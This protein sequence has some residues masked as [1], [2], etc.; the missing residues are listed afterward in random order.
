MEILD[1]KLIQ[2]GKFDEAIKICD[3]Q[4][5]NF[6]NNPERANVYE[7]AKKA[8]QAAQ[9]K[10]KEAVEATKSIE[11]TTVDP[12]DSTKKQSFYDKFIKDKE[13]FVTLCWLSA[14]IA[15]EKSSSSIEAGS[16]AAADELKLN[17]NEIETKYDI[18]DR[19]K[20]IT[21]QILEG[22]GVAKWLTRGCLAVG[23]G[24]ILAKGVTGYLAKE[25][26]MSG[27]LGLF[28][29]GKLGISKLPALWSAI[30][31][32]VT[33]LTGWSALFVGAAAG[34]AVLKT[35]PVVSNFVK[36]IKTKYKNAHTY[37]QGIESLL[38]S[39]EATNLTI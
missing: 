39:Q 8:L 16:V 30:G 3:K 37:E 6:K 17:A 36:S 28:G 35:I 1:P 12:T 2:K 27:A 10:L 13:D 22:K 4:A 31:T 18:I 9:K 26:I 24:E 38:K 19:T 33:A 15:S 14:K 34:F 5:K 32:G 7:N 25:G 23:L 11:T 29:L 21:K 20:R